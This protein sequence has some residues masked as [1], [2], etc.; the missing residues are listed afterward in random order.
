MR[1]K[2]KK[3]KRQENCKGG[4]ATVLSTTDKLGNRLL[5]DALSLHEAIN[6]D[7]CLA[8][9]IFKDCSKQAV[10]VRES[11]Q[12]SHMSGGESRARWEQAADG[13]LQRNRQIKAP[14]SIECLR[15]KM[16]SLQPAMIFR[17]VLLVACKSASR[18]AGLGCFKGMWRRVSDYPR[19][20]LISDRTTGLLCCSYDC[21][22][23]NWQGEH[24]FTLGF[25]QIE[26]E[27][28]AITLHFVILYSQVCI[29]GMH[30]ATSWT[31]SCSHATYNLYITSLLELWYLN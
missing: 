25:A 7:Y 6:H 12:A 22:G 30:G 13:E 19:K 31:V 2:S 10:S 5:T 21:I 4:S 24:L 17:K 15:D 23:F 29:L 14:C 9:F 1:K 11:I 16:G 20:F 8:W 18:R 26:D 28:L 3:K 27:M